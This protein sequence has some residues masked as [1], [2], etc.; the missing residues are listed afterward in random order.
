MQVRTADGLK[1]T[2]LSVYTSICCR[3]MR[4]IHVILRNYTDIFRYLPVVLLRLC[5]RYIATVQ[6]SATRLLPWN[7][8]REA[9]G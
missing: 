2:K 6:A 1:E 8:A 9:E 4:I 7:E 3:T 5:P